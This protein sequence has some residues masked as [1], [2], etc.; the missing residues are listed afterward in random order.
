MTTVIARW[1]ETAQDGVVSSRRL[2]NRVL[3]VNRLAFTV[4]F[5]VWTMYGCS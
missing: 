2:A 1:R 4:R 3:V 5:A